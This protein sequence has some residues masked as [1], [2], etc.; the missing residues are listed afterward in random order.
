MS[1]SLETFSIGVDIFHLHL[2]CG[3]LALGLTKEDWGVEG[4]NY[5]VFSLVAG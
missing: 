4:G 3:L 5:S 2:N 1:W